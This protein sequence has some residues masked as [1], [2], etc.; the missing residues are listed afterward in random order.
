MIFERTAIYSR[1]TSFYIYS[2]MVVHTFGIEVE[3]SQNSA[4]VVGARCEGAAQRGLFY[5]C[6]SCTVILGA[7]RHVNSST[8]TPQLPFKIR[9]IP[10]NR[11]YKALNRATLGGLGMTSTLA[12]DPKE[13]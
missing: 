7:P 11:D 13:T 12:P 3:L 2:R 1:Y 10:S 6:P 9:Q 5:P 8:S 4:G